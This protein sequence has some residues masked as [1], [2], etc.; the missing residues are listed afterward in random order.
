MTTLKE[1]AAVIMAAGRGSRMEGFDGNKTLLPLVPGASVFEGRR[2]ILRHV[3]QNLPPGPKALVVHHRRET[4]MAQ[5]ADMGVTYCYQPALNGT[6]GALLAA[7]AFLQGLTCAD[8]IITM[9]DVPFVRRETFERI[10][11]ELK[12]V[13]LV[14]LGFRPSDKKQYG[15]LEM[16][17]GLARR[18]VEWK[19]WKDYP[20]AEQ[21]ALQICNGGIYAARR[22]DLLKYLRVLKSRP[23]QVC[24]TI[25]GRLQ[26]F[27][28]YFLTDLVE[29]MADDGLPVGCW[30]ADEETEIMGVDDVQALKKAQRLYAERYRSTAS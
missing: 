27:D 1:T 23:Q 19:Y 8:V 11:A 15:L 14:V 28:E 29:Y 12:R 18:I 7:E 5:T 25:A 26:A 6:G 4:V 16:R 3:L 9:G 30:T 22:N 2:P 24:K 21:R 13:H 17:D 20:P 10:L